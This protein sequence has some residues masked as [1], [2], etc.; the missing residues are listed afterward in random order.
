V[1]QRLWETS[2]PS[3]AA[4]S[5]FVLLTSNGEAVELRF[6]YDRDGTTYTG[7]L[8]FH[9]VRA[10][11]HRAE[12]YLTEWHLTDAYDTLVEVSPSDWVET[13]RSAAPSDRRGDWTMRHFMITFDSAGCY[14][15]AAEDWEAFAEVAGRLTTHPASPLTPAAPA[16]SAAPWPRRDRG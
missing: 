5:G 3:T 15:I 1:K 16:G 9:R 12:L 4:V 10:H 11:R 8:R 2:A 13:L 7:G 14:E 6:D